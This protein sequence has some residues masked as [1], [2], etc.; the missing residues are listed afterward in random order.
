MAS[1]DYINFDI[2][3][4][5]FLVLSHACCPQ[6]I[7]KSEKTVLPTEHLSEQ[8][9]IIYNFGKSSLWSDQN[10]FARR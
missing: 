2:I 6:R 10:K 4:E 1:F 5:M 9:Q 7:Q 3:Q 8:L